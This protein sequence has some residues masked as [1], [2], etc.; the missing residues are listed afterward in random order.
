MGESYEKLVRDKIPEILDK[1]GVPYEKRFASPEEYKTELVK[2]LSEE[3]TEFTE[4]NGSPEELADVLEVI[5]AIKK[6][7]EYSEV[8]EIQQ[9]KRE[10]KGAF[11]DHI[12]VKGQKP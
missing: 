8:T 10:E 9:K 2:K 5:E 3:V 12:I 1:K 11:N 6:L 7:P 4:S